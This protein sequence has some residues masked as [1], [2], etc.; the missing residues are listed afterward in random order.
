[1]A[2]FD[3]SQ[4]QNPPADCQKLSRVIRSTRGL[5]GDMHIF[6]LSF[7][8]IYPYAFF[9]SNDLQVGSWCT[10]DQNMR[11]HTRFKPLGFVICGKPAAH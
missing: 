1:M 4:N 10:I 3:P 7:F 6:W 9:P 2:K 8:F 11:Y 5:Q